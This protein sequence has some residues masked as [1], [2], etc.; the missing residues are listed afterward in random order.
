MS[1]FGPKDPEFQRRENEHVAQLRSEQTARGDELEALL[2]DAD[3]DRDAARLIML[4]QLLSPDAF[5]TRETMM[6][7]VRRMRSGPR[8]NDPD[9]AE[10]IQVHERVARLAIEGAVRKARQVLEMVGSWD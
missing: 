2:R 5:S 8:G 6:E 7:N 10:A 9:F 4:A 3:W 1:F